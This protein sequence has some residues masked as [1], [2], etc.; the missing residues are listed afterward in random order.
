[1]LFLRFGSASGAAGGHPG[2]GFGGAGFEGMNVQV[3]FFNC[4]FIL[5]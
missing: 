3:T 1:L 5:A 4:F 2:G